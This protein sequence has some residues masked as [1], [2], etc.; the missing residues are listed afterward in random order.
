MTRQA[1]GNLF[2]SYTDDYDQLQPLRIEMYQ[3]YHD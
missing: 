3:F 1:T 2:S